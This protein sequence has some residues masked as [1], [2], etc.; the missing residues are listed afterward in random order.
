MGKTGRRSRGGLAAQVKRNVPG[1]LSRR[2]D[3][4]GELRRR[5]PTSSSSPAADAAARA[6]HHLQG[7]LEAAGAQQQMTA[8]WR[9]ASSYGCRVR[10]RL[11]T[12]CAAAE[13]CPVRH[14]LP[15]QQWSPGC[16]CAT[17][18][19]GMCAWCA[20]MSMR[21]GQASPGSC[22]RWVRSTPATWPPAACL[23]LRSIAVL[24][25]GVRSVSLF[26]LP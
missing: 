16:P 8:R 15:W 14:G 10:T 3:V 6:E 19:H 4:T 13:M 11:G 24:A 25:H 20:C 26:V 9:R 1:G 18:L 21:A 22:A 12:A 17:A 7:L 5:A 23:H 2:A